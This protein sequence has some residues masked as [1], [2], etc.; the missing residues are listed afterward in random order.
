[1][2]VFHREL[3][4]SREEMQNLIQAIKTS[5]EDFQRAATRIETLEFEWT[6]WHTEDGQAPPA[7]DP[8]P[9]L[10]GSSGA[11]LITQQLEDLLGF[12][13]TNQGQSPTDGPT[14]FQLTPNYTPRSGGGQEPDR[15]DSLMERWR[16][17]SPQGRPQALGPARGQVPEGNLPQFTTGDRATVTMGHDAPPGFG[18]T[19]DP[20]IGNLSRRRPEIFIPVTRRAAGETGPGGVVRPQ[21]TLSADDSD[22]FS[23]FAGMRPRNH[24]EEIPG[25]LQGRGSTSLEDP[26]TLYSTATS[27]RALAPESAGSPP[28]SREAELSQSAGRGG[29]STFQSMSAVSPAPVATPSMGELSVILKTLQILS[30]SFRSSIPEIQALEPADSSSGFCKPRS[31]LSLPART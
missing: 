13:H 31:R 30:Q 25:G 6:V 29:L 11:G 20:T 18:L 1:M 27:S 21:A 10:L 12:D 16:N 4:A 26:P 7:R 15:H 14:E 17:P 23:F 3:S 8:P 28:I 2:M 9:E 24:L 5:Q 22:V 19:M